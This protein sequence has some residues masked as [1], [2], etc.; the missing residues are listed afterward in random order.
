M[1]FIFCY[2]ISEQKRLNRVAKLLEKKGIRVQLS[3]FEVDLPMKEAEKLF[4]EISSMIDSETDRIFMYRCIDVYSIGI[5][6]G[7]FYV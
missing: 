2:D 3:I 4:D 7:S 5:D 1:K 6:K